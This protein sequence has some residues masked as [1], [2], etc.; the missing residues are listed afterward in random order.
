MK[1]FLEKNPLVH[2]TIVLTIVAIACGLLI[3]GI[4]AW[5]NPI[6]ED[7]NYQRK[8]AAYQSVLPDLADDGLTVLDIA[9]DP[10]NIEEKVE[11]KDD[12][13]NV[14]GYI[15]NINQTNGYGNMQIVMAIASDGTIISAE[16]LQLN[17]TLNLDNT[18]ANLAMYVGTNIN[19]LQNLDFLS[20]ATRSL[21]TLT[22]MMSDIQSAFSTIDIDEPVDETAVRLARYQALL[23]D[24]ASFTELDLSTDPNSIIIKAALYDSG[25]VLM[26][27][28]IEAS[29]SNGFG[30]LHLVIVTDTNGEIVGADFV[31]Y[32]NSYFETEMNAAIADLV[33]ETVTDDLTDGFALAAPSS[34]DT[35]PSMEALMSDISS[36]YR[37]I[38]TEGAG[39]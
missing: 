33:G 23:T 26:G 34:T 20:G 28:A 30:L 29:T 12:E 21:E 32:G 15:I 39:A 36:A 3:G 13:G 10:D 38:D 37:H 24:T 4:N 8:V 31:N 7:N 14:I 11:A 27:Y 2:Y 16:F 18:R 22:A 25:D 17:Q 6:I 1:N 5:T 9:N 19:T 35:V